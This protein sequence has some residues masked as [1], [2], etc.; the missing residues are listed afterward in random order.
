MPRM[1]TVGK[2]CEGKPLARF[3]EGELEIG[4]SFVWL[5]KVENPET[6]GRR[7]YTAPVLYST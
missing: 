7:N 5:S 4:S 3:D 2:P 6:R 1:K